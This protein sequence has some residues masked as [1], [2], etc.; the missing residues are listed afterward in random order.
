MV[1]YAEID[2]ELEKEFHIEVIRRYGLGK[3]KIIIEIMT[4]PESPSDYQKK[5]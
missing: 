2:E 5:Y 1:V 3:M 4:K